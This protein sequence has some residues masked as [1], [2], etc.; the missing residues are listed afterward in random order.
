MVYFCI[1]IA[2]MNLVTLIIIALG[3]SMD[4]FTVSVSCG[5]IHRKVILRDF[6]LTAFFMGLFQGG[7]TMI[8]YYLGL[9]F[10][11]HIE[12][13]DHWIA[14][15]L[16]FFLGLKMIYEGSKHEA[17]RNFCPS[18]LNVIIGLSIATSIDALAIGVSFAI[19]L[20]SAPINASTIIA[21]TTFF[22]SLIGIFMG[23]RFSKSRKLPFEIIGGIILIGIGL[24]ILLEHTVLL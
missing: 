22:M 8:G 19:L 5:V 16:L 13:L 20:N 15:G 10:K 11:E 6:L 23:A 7:M 2:K 12:S 18:K 1:L 14:F 21:V 3:L 24:K 17:K 9:S 4:S